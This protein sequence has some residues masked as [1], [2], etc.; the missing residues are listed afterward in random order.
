MSAKQND[1][2]LLPARAR[3]FLLAK[4]NTVLSPASVGSLDFDFV[5][6]QLEADPDVEIQQRLTPR[7]FRAQ[8]LGTS[9]TDKIV[10]A[11]IPEQTV[12]N[13]IR[14]PQVLVEE[15]SFILPQPA[16]SSVQ[17][18][19]PGLLSPFGTTTTWTIVLTGSGQQP[20]AG[21]TVYLYGSGTPA[22]GRTDS[23]GSVTLSLLNESDSTIRAIYINPQAD[24]WSA[25]IDRPQLT[26]GAT[27]T[28]PLAPLSDSFPGFPDSE[29][30]GWGQRA[31]RLDQVPATFT[32]RGIKVA[33]VDSGAAA[34]THPDLTDMREGID[35]TSTPS[36]YEQWKDDTI[37]HGSH[38]SGII[39]GAQNGGGVKG[40][41]PE[42][43]MHQARI[44][45]GGRISSLIDAVDYCIDQGIDVV[46]MS[47]G[48]G[49]SSQIMLQKLAQAKELGVACIVAA[50]NT[51]G[52]VQ[53]P[54]TS[55]DVLTVAA[56]GKN[57]EFPESSYHAQQRWKNG[58][59]DLGFFSAQFSCHGERIDVCGPGVAV[60]SS[61]PPSGFAAW[62]G[63]SMATPHIAGLAALV[64]GHHPDFQSGPLQHKGAARVDRLFDLLKSSST[65]L[66]FGDPQRSG[67]GLPDSMRALGL[68]QNG[69]TGTSAVSQDTAVQT[70]LAQ[71][72][73]ELIAAGLLA[74]VMNME[75]P[76]ANTGQTV[77][78]ELEEV[79]AR[80]LNASLS[81]A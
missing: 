24:Y 6:E 7:T 23:A 81:V 41:A 16:A 38:C 61:V 57:D 8:V 51:G 9:I 25:W 28:I 30:I 60:V 49:G 76:A 5:I 35:L 27:T 62:D 36:N 73:K 59:D 65:P 69:Q 79:R 42:A 37:A 4:D 26:S 45:P 40:F 53:F 20:V 39:A 52:D 43:E 74:E 56:I 54:G 14:H 44:F 10:V 72:N 2:P 11:T 34:L 46:N 70:A 48:T 19:D 13:L 18:I 66:Q 3:T 64:L 47:L 12:A 71:L 17:E 77:Q 31:M 55:P 32:G 63:T 33:V 67:A 80:M 78:R 21:A 58:Q 29:L 15:D 68:E 50:G 1:N 75:P 22:Q